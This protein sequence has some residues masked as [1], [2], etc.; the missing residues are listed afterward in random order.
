MPRTDLKVICNGF[1]HK[2]SAIAEMGHR[3]HNRHGLKRR[4]GCLQGAGTDNRQ[5][6]IDA[7]ELLKTRASAEPDDFCLSVIQS[8]PTRRTPVLDGSN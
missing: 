5:V 6:E 4:R 3:G 8:Q 7:S 1:S 2:R